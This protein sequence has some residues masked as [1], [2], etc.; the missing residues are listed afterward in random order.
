MSALFDLL[1]LVI[2]LSFQ[3]EMDLP[4]NICCRTSRAL[5]IMPYLENGRTIEHAH[6]IAA[7]ESPGTTQL[8]DRTGDEIMLD[9][10]EWI[11]I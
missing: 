1:V 11:G 2:A 6:A 4:P 3:E 10:V 8:C 7:R 5:G 9:D